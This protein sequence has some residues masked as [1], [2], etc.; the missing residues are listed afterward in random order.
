MKS[1]KRP[2]FFAMT[3]ILITGQIYAQVL[4]PVAKPT[5]PVVVPNPVVK[6]AVKL[7]PVLMAAM[8]RRIQTVRN[9]IIAAAP[10]GIFYSLYFNDNIETELKNLLAVGNIPFINGRLNQIVNRLASDISRGRVLPGSVPDKAAIIAKPY[11]HQV[12]SDQFINSKMTNEDFLLAVVPKNRIYQQAQS[13]VGRLIEMKTKNTWMTKPAALKLGIVSKKTINPDLI[14][15]ARGSLENLGYLN[16][17]ISTVY[18]TD[19]ETALKLFQADNGLKNDGVAGDMSW[20]ILNRPVDQLISQAVMNLDRTR[21]LPDVNP[22]EYIY[23]NLAQQQFHY[24]E[25]EIETLTFKTVNGRLDRQTPLMVDVARDVVLN[26]TWT[27]PRNLFVKDKIPK[28]LAD[29]TWSLQANMIMYSDIDNSV[30]DPTTVDW[31]LPPEQLPYTLVQSPGPSNA[32]G[33]IK[34]PLKNG[35]S[36]Y[37]HDTNERYLFETTDRLK[38]SGCMRLEK[39]FELAEKLLAGTKWTAEALRAASEFSPVPAEKQSY[40]T[41]RRPVPVYVS[42]KTLDVVN[43]HLISSNDPYEVDITMYNVFATGK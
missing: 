13:I 36:I 37:M 4:P 14:L 27:V 20:A 8:N 39:P 24:F 9:L 16:N 6:P 3:T 43:G 29:P 42:Y 34:F 40:I 10:H 1:S 28:L 21:W 5:A 30:V 2:L 12:I 35:F 15:F 23:I 19:L 26:P 31:T 41:M 18:D 33:F 32:L 11:L 25:N 17:K 7:S 22:A 38:S